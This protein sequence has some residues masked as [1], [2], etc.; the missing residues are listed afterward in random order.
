M[1]RAVTAEG[2]PPAEEVLRSTLGPLADRPEVDAA[3]LAAL[4]QPV[5]VHPDVG[6]V[7]GPGREDQMGDGVEIGSVQQGWCADRAGRR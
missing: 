7:G 6:D 4:H 3:D 2:G 1:G 5:A